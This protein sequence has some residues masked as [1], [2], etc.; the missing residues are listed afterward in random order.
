LIREVFVRRLRVKE[1]GRI[2]SGVLQSFSYLA[3]MDT[4]RFRCFLLSDSGATASCTCKNIKKYTSSK[5]LQYYRI[6]TAQALCINWNNKE[7]LHCTYRESGTSSTHE[8]L[9]FSHIDMSIDLE[10]DLDHWGLIISELTL[11]MHV[12]FHP[13]ELKILWHGTCVI[14]AVHFEIGT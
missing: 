8:T 12:K 14:T 11:A 10:L 2:C 1:W 4:V 5:I 7:F 3:T 13:M 9:F 6:Y